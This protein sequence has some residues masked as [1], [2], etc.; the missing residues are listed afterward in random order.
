MNMNKHE[1][2]NTPVT[3]WKHAAS[4]LPSH[5]LAATST[6]KDIPF[7]GF[8]IAKSE[9]ARALVVNVL[10]SLQHYESL[11]NLRQRARKAKDQYTFERQ[12]EALVCDLAYKQI[13][14]PG[15]WTAIPFSKAVLGK[16]DRYRAEVLGKTLPDVVRLLAASELRFV[17]FELGYLNPFNTAERKQ[18]TIRAGE[19]LQSYIE[20]QQLTTA[21]LG[22][23]KTGETII[24]KASKDAHWDKGKWIQYDDT[25]QT[26]EY[27][28]D[29]TRINDWLDQADL[30]YVPYETSRKTVDVSD[31]LLRRYFNN[32]SFE[33]GGRLFGGFWQGMKKQERAEG[34][35]IDGTPVVTLDYGQMVPRILYG[36]AGVDPHFDD[37]YAVPGLE[38]YRDGVK[39][40]FNAML[41]IGKPLTKKPKGSADQLPQ[42]R[43][44]ADIAALVTDFHQLV[45]KAFYADRGLYFS[46]LESRILITVLIRLLEQKIVAL[47]IHDAVIVPENRADQTKQIMLE[48]FRELAGID[49]IVDYET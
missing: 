30:E 3:R 42:E 17:E 37:A 40:V 15:A 44:I 6:P 20:E 26:L 11:Y 9:K 49:G 32:T 5:Q 18:T 35:L 47:P 48:V 13:N 23:N 46:Y 41:H 28:A 8:R 16:K 29:L 7:N 14:R 34:I 38:G 25:P 36:Q 24:L 12:V 31:R 45:A 27:R 19:I 4:T 2:M 21:D 1:G 39:K 10:Q 43:S 22:L 33:Q